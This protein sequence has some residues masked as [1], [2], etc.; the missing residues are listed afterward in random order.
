MRPT[1]SM[2]LTGL[3]AQHAAMQRELADVAC[4]PWAALGVQHALRAAGVPAALR[5]SDE[6]E[7]T[8]EH[9]E[10]A[11]DKETCVLYCDEQTLTEAEVRALSPQT[12]APW[13]WTETR[14]L[15]PPTRDRAQDSRLARMLFPE[16]ESML[17]DWGPHAA[18]GAADGG[19]S[20]DDPLPRG[21]RAGGFSDYWGDG[22]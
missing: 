21:W 15:S 18:A 11:E 2:P 4:G 17:D 6:D 7:A 3:Q 16:L 19:A 9:T 22:E 8:G 12:L 5:G 13:T 1:P 20:A 14:A 10:T